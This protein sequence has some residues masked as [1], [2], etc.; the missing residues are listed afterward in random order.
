MDNI[1]AMEMENTMRMFQRKKKG[2]RKL[3]KFLLIDNFVKYLF[4]P[5]YLFIKL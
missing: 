4:K 1:E 3:I 5:N 2:E